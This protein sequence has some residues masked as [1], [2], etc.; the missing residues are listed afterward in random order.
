MVIVTDADL[1]SLLIS[2]TDLIIDNYFKDFFE[3][4]NGLYI[5]IGNIEGDIIATK[6]IGSPKEWKKPL[7]ENRKGI[8]TTSS[9]KIYEL[10]NKLSDKSFI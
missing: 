6:L 1:E 3:Q 7:D 9:H 4:N 5:L 10:I 2:F 8:I